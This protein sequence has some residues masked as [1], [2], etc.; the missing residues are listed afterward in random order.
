V[1]VAL[2]AALLPSLAAEAGSGSSGSG[3]AARSS[4]SA[5]GEHG[6]VPRWFQVLGGLLAGRQAVEQVVSGHGD[7]MTGEELRA[8]VA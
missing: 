3:R 1:S 5:E 8:Q 2:A 4:R 6:D 7:P